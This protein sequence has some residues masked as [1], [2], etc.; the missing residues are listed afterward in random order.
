M[1]GIPT[2]R[3]VRLTFAALL[4]EEGVAWCGGLCRA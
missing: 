4:E 3:P 1:I 2:G